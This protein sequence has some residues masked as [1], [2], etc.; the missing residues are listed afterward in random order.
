MKKSILSVNELIDKIKNLGYEV[1]QTGYKS[2]KDAKNNNHQ[3]RMWVI[4]NQN[5]KLQRSPFYNTESDFI[6]FTTIDNVRKILKSGNIRLFSLNHMDDSKEL[7]YA[8]HRLGLKSLFS[9]TLEEEKGKIYS[10]SMCSANRVLRNKAKEHLL[11][12][13]H[14]RDGKGAALKLRLVN[15]I[16]LWHNFHLTKMFYGTQHFT[17]IKKLAKTT[18]SEILDNK[19][20]SF[21]KDPIFRFEDEYRVIFDKRHITRVTDAQDTLIYPITVPCDSAASNNV[22]YFE[23][24]LVNFTDP[25]SDKFHAHNMEGLNY[26][27]PKFEISEIILGYRFSDVEMKDIGAELNKIGGGIKTNRTSL[28]RKY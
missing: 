5:Y 1:S 15:G 26:E 24:P 10:F 6:H 7:Q 4:P 25:C 27:L 3:Y 11:W 19:I 2:Q 23:L 16:E 20:A 17:A 13:I 22:S 12:K 8:M 18:Q 9:H 21:I 14:G 28:R